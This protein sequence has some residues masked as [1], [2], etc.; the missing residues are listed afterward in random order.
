VEQQITF[1]LRAERLTPRSDGSYELVL[2]LTPQR[3]RDEHS[4]AN[5]K[6]PAQRNGRDSARP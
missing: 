6:P 3:L 5:P 2:I 1:V 4:A